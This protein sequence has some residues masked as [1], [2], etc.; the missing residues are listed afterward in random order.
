MLNVIILAG[1]TRK[2]DLEIMEKVDNKAYIKIEGRTMI[3]IIIKTLREVQEIGEIIVV[4]MPAELEK[5]KIEEYRFQAIP[6]RGSFLDNIAAG[7]SEVDPDKPCLVISADIPL[8]SKEALEDLIERCS[9][10]DHD[11][12]YPIISREHC[13]ESYPG[14]QR[15]YVQLKEGTFTGSN[16]MMVKPYWILEQLDDINVYLSYRKKPWKIVQTLPLIFIIKFIIKRLTIKELESYLSGLFK[17]KAR[18]VITPYAE[19]GVDVDKPSDLELARK[20]LS[21]EN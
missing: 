20:L 4:G 16:I 7:L 21:K 8:L 18:A 19:I 6:P 14:V 9:P 10:C 11:F 3:E 13:E 17:I 1:A 15:T 12:Y 5:L 2:G